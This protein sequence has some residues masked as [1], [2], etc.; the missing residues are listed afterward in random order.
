[1]P[2]LGS[3]DHESRQASGDKQEAARF[4]HR[5]I[6]VAD[7]NEDS[8]LSMAMMLKIMG[9]DVRMARDGVEAVEAAKEFR[10]EMILLDIGMPRMNGYDAC[11]RIREMDFGRDVIIVALTGWGQD[12]DKRRSKEAGF[13]RHLIKPIDP[14]A[15]EKLLAVLQS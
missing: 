8:A 4:V 1:L 14:E 12:E 11:R 13:D 10:P 6:L 7:D 9:N 15:I 3:L 5:R 2:V